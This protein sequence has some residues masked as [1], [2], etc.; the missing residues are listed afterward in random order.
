MILILGIYFIKKYLLEAMQLLW[1]F[2]KGYFYFK[3]I[4]F[5][6]EFLG[7]VIYFGVNISNGP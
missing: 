3:H 7:W 2:N 4:Y 6:H 5:F 1:V